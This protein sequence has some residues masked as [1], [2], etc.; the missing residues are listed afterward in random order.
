MPQ[1]YIDNQNQMNNDNLNNNIQNLE[2]YETEERMINSGNINQI[3]GNAINI[4]A[5]TNQSIDINNNLNQIGT[6]IFSQ[7]YDD[8]LQVSQKDYDMNLSSRDNPL[9][10]SDDEGN[11][12]YLEKQYKAYKDRMNQNNEDDM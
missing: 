12:N 6:L 10:Y 4:S 11:M 5:Y 2:N 3:N 7:D 8:Q 1:Y 9:I